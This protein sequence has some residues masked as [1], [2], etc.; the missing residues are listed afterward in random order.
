MLAGW[1]VN[2]DPRR[3]LPCAT[4]PLHSAQLAVWKTP[5]PR[6]TL[7]QHHLPHPLADVDECRLAAGHNEERPSGW[8]MPMWIVSLS[9]K[10]LMGSALEGI[11]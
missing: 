8:W 6:Q 1:S 11:R 7:K 10:M 5:Q 9:R 3:I 2:L 4:S